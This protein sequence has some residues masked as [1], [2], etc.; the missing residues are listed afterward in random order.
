MLLGRVAPPPR[1]RGWR[2]R[3][4]DFLGGAAAVAAL[5]AADAAVEVAF[6]LPNSREMER[7]ADSVGARPRGSARAT[8]QALARA[9]RRR[10]AAARRASRAAM[11]TTMP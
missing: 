10:A 7:E 3:G 9:R 8:I 1:G 11:E 2:R 6:A 5:D 4:V